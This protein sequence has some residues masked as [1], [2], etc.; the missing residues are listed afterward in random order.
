M[1][2][3]EVL[4]PNSMGTILMNTGAEILT[5]NTGLGATPSR[6]TLAKP[7][8]DRSQTASAEPAL[9]NVRIQK[10]KQ[11]GLPKEEVGF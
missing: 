8:M 10:A 5:A 11:Y 1:D 3:M 7:L 4:Q 2:P 9:D 6:G